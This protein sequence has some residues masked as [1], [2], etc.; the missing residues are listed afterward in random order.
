MPSLTRFYNLNRGLAGASGAD[1]G[2]AHKPVLRVLV[3]FVQLKAIV[4]LRLTQMHPV[5]ISE[6][7]EAIGEGFKSLEALES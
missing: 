6:V 4:S 3:V 1:C 7:H 5:F 2:V